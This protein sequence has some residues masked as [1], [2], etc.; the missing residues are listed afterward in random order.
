[1]QRVNLHGMYRLGE[2]LLPLKSRMAWSESTKLGSLYSKLATARGVFSPF[3]RSLGK[4]LT[5]SK[6][7]AEKIGELLDGL[8]SPLDD[9]SADISAA[10]EKEIDGFEANALAEAIERFETVFAE[11]AA[12]IN[13]YLVD[14]KGPYDIGRI[15]SGAEK[16]LTPEI[17]AAMPAPAVDDY[18]EAG[19]CLAFAVF[20]AS[21]F[22]VLRSL[23]TVVVAYL[24]KKSGK[25]VSERFRTWGAYAEALE[26]AHG[27]PELVG[28]VRQIKDLHRNPLMHPE[29][30]LD[31]EE[32]IILF[33]LVT[34]AIVAF[35][36]ETIRTPEPE[37][38]ARP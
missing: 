22:H 37:A 38:A 6:A 9:P 8:L 11:E 18:R 36:R 4:R 25:P 32:G 3:L 12:L 24:V 17:Q 20:T 5:T 26:K 14:P 33:G 13:A 7:P 1:M 23:E 28:M 19:R 31:E 21:G 16:T 34:S 27:K 35:V 10:F 2:A 29:D 30:F 15:V